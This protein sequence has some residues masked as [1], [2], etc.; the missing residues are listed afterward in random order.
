MKLDNNIK[1]TIRMSLD[2][3]ARAAKLELDLRSE[4]EIFNHIFKAGIESLEE[5]QIEVPPITEIE[6]PEKAEHIEEKP[7]PDI[8]PPEYDQVSEGY[9]API[10]ADK[11]ASIF[12]NI[13]DLEF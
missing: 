8:E 9:K 11:Q 3:Y 4:N 10:E 1:K 7:N 6:E 5:Q 13:K 2:L 12:S